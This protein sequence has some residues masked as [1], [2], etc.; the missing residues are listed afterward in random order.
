MTMHVP[1]TAKDAGTFSPGSEA[2]GLYMM[3]TAL[4]RPSVALPLEGS[5]IHPRAA[6]RLVAVAAR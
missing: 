1:R 6:P 2:T 5:S 4:A 3:P